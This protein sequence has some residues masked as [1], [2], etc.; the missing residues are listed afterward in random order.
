ML[1]LLFL[2]C[3]GD[4]TPLDDTGFVYSGTNN[5]LLGAGPLEPFP[6]ADLVVDGQLALPADLLPHAESEWPTDRVG[7]RTGFSPIQALTVQLPGVD[8]AALPSWRG[9][10]PGAGGVRLVDLDSGEWY[11]VMAELDAWPDDNPDPILI[12]RPQAAMPVG[13]TM[14]VVITTDVAPRPDRY[15][16]IL[17]GDNPTDLPDPAHARDLVARLGELGVAADDVALAWD[18]PVG[19]GTAPLRSALAQA[20][21]PTTWTLDRVHEAGDVR[22]PNGWR[23]A[24]GR[25]T[26][27]SFLLD[28]LKLDLQADGSVL[29]TGETNAY[30]YIHVPEGVKDAPANSVPVLV[31]SHGLFGSG[32]DLLDVDYTSL[33]L[34]IADRLGMIVVATNWVG[35]DGN[36]QASAITAARDLGRLPE[37][38]DQVVQGQVNQ[39]SLMELV[40]SGAL[41]TEPVLQ[42]ASGQPLVNPGQIYLCGVSMGSIEGAVLIGNDAPVQASV[43]HIGGADWS[44]LLERSNQ[45]ASFELF[46]VPSL[47]DPHDRQRAYA[48]SQLWW[49]VVDGMSYTER[50]AQA[51]IL[52]QEALGDD[53]VH[54]MTTRT[55]AR[56]AG[57]SVLVPN[58]ED[59]FGIPHVGSDF[60]A[61]SPA[62][63]QVDPERGEPPDVNRPS[64]NTGAHTAAINWAGVQAQAADFLNPAHPGLLVD[65]CG[66]AVCTPENPGE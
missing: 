33:P 57:L 5:G 43:L 41:D 48:L 32:S 25:F 66:G 15:A 46:V 14:A 64:P 63:V 31:Y 24:E 50:L 54:N 35:L 51:P 9:L 20:A 55:L 52:L 38:T 36:S 27:T 58:T 8:P 22:A 26:A 30:L 6:N 65:H 39:R 34:S 47:P 29:P 2:A 45:W 40:A 62:L 4:D 18:F 56:S 12:V 23:T 3:S 59:A 60:R 53:L 28:G 17:V 61:G 11:P 37:L 7:W 19:D 44:T 13:A 10:T 1:L 21:V 16:G 49:D 42:G